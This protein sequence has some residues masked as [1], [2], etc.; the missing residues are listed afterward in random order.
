MENGG[1]GGEGDGEREFAV[2]I[3]ATTTNGHQRVRVIRNKKQ[4]RVNREVF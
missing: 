3:S 4:D 1:V 2:C